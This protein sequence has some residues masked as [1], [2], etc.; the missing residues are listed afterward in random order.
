MKESFSFVD[1][2]RGNRY[3]I[4]FRSEIGR[5]DM[6]QDAGYV[7]ACDSE[8]LAVVCDGM[9]GMSGGEQ[10]S[11]AA[12]EKFLIEYEKNGRLGS[13]W[14]EEAIELVDDLV[15][16]LRAPDGNRLG[17]GT[18]LVAVHITGDSIS[19]VSAGDSRLYIIRAHQMVQVTTDHNYFFQLDE[20]LQ[21]G[22]ID[23]EKY[24]TESRD[25]D[26]LISY[27][28]M[29]G[30]QWKDVSRTPLHLLPGDTLLLCTDGLYRAVSDEQI[31][32]S[33]YAEKTMDGAAERL[34]NAVH[35]ADLPEQ[36]NYTYIL[37]HLNGGEMQ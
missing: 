18:T 35:S 13:N 31:L 36:D 3:D 30:L 11:R 21:R 22:E 1:L 28:G 33:A 37:I 29:G 26:A 19:W 23:Q 14:M 20:M 4:A 24:L 6:Q 32:L 8:V 27:A 17:A 2:R 5:R 9:G 16:S 15:F 25:G 7:A 10:A 12:V 34:K